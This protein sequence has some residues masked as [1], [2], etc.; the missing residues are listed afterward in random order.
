MR[1]QNH[2][3]LLGEPHEAW[4]DG[5]FLLEH[6]EAGARDGARLDELGQRASSMISPR[7]V[8]TTIASGFMSFRRRAESRW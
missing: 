7:A 5:R 2:L 4:I 1:Q 6:V 8:F 3:A